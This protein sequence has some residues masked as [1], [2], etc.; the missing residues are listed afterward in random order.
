[1]GINSKIVDPLEKKQNEESR[2]NRAISDKQIELAEL[3]RTVNDAKQR[4]SDALK[5]INE[6]MTK[7]QKE[8]E[9]YLISIGLAYKKGDQLV[10]TRRKR[11]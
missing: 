7:A 6:E 11:G 3:I 4:A 2:L 5:K 10:V 9:N 8:F 1:M